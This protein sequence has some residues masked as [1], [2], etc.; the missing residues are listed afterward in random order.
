MDSGAA[1]FAGSATDFVRM[2][3]ESSLTTHLTKEFNRRWGTASESEIRSW[4][5]SLTALALVVEGSSLPDLGVGVELKL[6]LSSKRIDVSLVGRGQDRRPGVVLVELKQWSGAAPSQNPDNVIVGGKELLHPS[7]QVGAYA[8]YLRESHS[9]FTE[10]GFSLAACSYLHGMARADSAAIKGILY[11]GAL[12]EA[13]LFTHD[14]QGDLK[15]Y[16][17][18]RLS[19]GG[20][21]DLLSKLVKGRFMPSKRLM[22]GIAVALR[23]SPQWIL[24]DEQRLTF[25]IVRGLVERAAKQ[26]PKAVVIISGGPGTGKSVVAAHLLAKLG[27]IGDRSVCH[28]TG[29]K[30]FTTN[31][32]AI[33][34]KGGASVFRYF[35]NF[36]P[37]DQPADGI[38]LVICDEAHRLRE[39]SN[40]RFTPAAKKSDMTQTAEIIRASKV[41]VFFLDELQNV[42][43]G[44]QGTVEGI[45]GEALAAGA[46]VHLL[47]L[48]GQ[49]RC[50]GCSGYIDWVEALFSNDPPAPGGWFR[51]GEY[52]LQVASSPE[53]LETLTLSKN[54][55]PSTARLVAG[56]CWPWSDPLADGKLVPDVVVGAWKRPWNAKPPEQRKPIR[57]A[58]TPKKHPYFEWASDPAHAGEVGCIYTAQG[59]EFDYCGVILGPDLVWR[60]GEGWVGSREG[61]SDP[62]ISRRRLSQQQVRTLVAQTYRVLLTR[63]M[64]GTFLYSTDWETQQKLTMLVGSRQ[65][66]PS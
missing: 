9:A 65:S 21:V 15:G 8:S 60:E 47:A 13:P 10:D 28:A 7:V 32:R 26:S 5:Q 66:D 27:A 39:T 45:Q 48:E 37:A 11:G 24:L 23:E 44:E 18:G 14:D 30:A 57:A 2:A 16:L 17:E 46:Q 4:R 41:S 29:S 12:A 42:R 34:P 64:K 63:G 59:F 25:N 31:L 40:D 22:D 58:P 49:F 51:A 62:S 53:Q 38:D 19:G 55:A 43:P 6:P 36:R 1:L 61:S 50:S 56:F 54:R 52:E 33:A 3:P 20:G 35:N